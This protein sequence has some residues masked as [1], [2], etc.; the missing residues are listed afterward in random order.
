VSS[1]GRPP[2]PTASSAPAADEE[3]QT[4]HQP[5]PEA[6]AYP[7]APYAWFVVGVLVLAS[8]I[9]YVDR[10]VVALLVEPMR[11]DLNISDTQVG[12][13]FS[14]FAIFYAVA[15]LPLAYLAD[16]VNRRWLITIGIFF[17]S[18]MTIGCGLARNFWLLLGARIGVGVGEAVLTPSAHSLIGDYFPREKIPLAVAVFQLSGTLG[19][20]IAF[21]VGGVIVELV[22]HAPPVD[23][24]PFGFL[25][26]WQMVF[27]YVGAPGML[28]ILL[29]LAVREPVR[30][31]IIQAYAGKRVGLGALWA[32]YRRNWRTML[33]HHVGFGAISLAGFS[34]VFW[35]PT[36]FQRI[37]GVPAGVAGAYYGLYFLT[38]ATIGTYVGAWLGQHLYRK[39]HKDWPMRGTLMT[40]WVMIPLGL[41]AP[42]VPW[43]WLAWVLYAPLMFFI[44]VPFGMAY[45][46]L[47]VIVPNQMRAQVAAI[48]L[49]LGSAVGMGLGPVVVGAINDHVFPE[50]DG[51]RYSLMFMMAAC[52]PVWI[53]L[54]WFGRRAYACSL[55]EAEALEAA[56]G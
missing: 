3:E 29:M 31:G 41:L 51:V 42:S 8:L 20:G 24:G 32:F 27:I 9:S 53:G 25:K 4:E 1:I 52:A 54:L 22:K 23:A 36:F 37:H 46:A 38:F 17:W 26:A 14:G 34:F 50:A 15:G 48:Y 2:A 12:W 56:G 6:K 13:L 49:M 10:Q 5:S 45:G 43:A 35:T 16:R 28:A 33:S 19:T 30:R 44:N 39:G 21:T 18:L 47:P 7:P 40:A 11:R 55:R